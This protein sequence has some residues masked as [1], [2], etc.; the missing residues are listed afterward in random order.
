MN[1]G[2]ISLQL[3]MD[4]FDTHNQIENKSPKTRSWYRD[5]LGQFRAYL[6]AHG[7]S[8]VL[9]DIDIHRV[10]DFILYLQSKHKWDDHPS[11]PGHGRKLSPVSVRTKV[12]AIRAFFSWVYREGFTD[13]N[14]LAD[15]KP[16]KAPRKLVRVLTLEEIRRLV[17]AIDRR[18]IS[19][20][21]N[22]A[23]LVTL[24]DTG[25]RLSEI[26]NLQMKNV[27]MDSGYV[28]VFGKGSKE[29]IVPVGATVRSALQRYI[30]FSR[31]EGAYPDI[32]NVFLALDG[33]P[34]TGNA[35][36]LVLK[37]LGKRTGIPRLHPHLCRHTFA[38]NYLMNGG[39]VFSLQQILGHTTLE[40]V[41]RYVTLASPQ[42]ISQHRKFSPMDRMR[43]GRRRQSRRK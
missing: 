28:K 8:T 11:I 15:L 19:G 34:M 32:D 35:I 42:V 20:A 43:I 31:G 30:A 12:R 22:F 24:L 10:R 4:Q 5:S 38:V 9:G 41:R 2:T 13:E 39:D 40:M 23:L 21:R 33:F 36:Y 17:S 25:L 27:L 6:E 26:A 18:T 29:R 37:R 16:P 14:L 1:K 7:L 3:L